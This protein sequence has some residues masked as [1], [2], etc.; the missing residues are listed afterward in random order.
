MDRRNDWLG[1]EQGYWKTG[2]RAEEKLAHSV[3]Q[4]REA[5]GFSGELDWDTEIVPYLTLEELIGAVLHG[6]A[7]LRECLEEI[8]ETEE[9]RP[10]VDAKRERGDRRSGRRPLGAPC[11][12]LRVV[13]IREL[14]PGGQPGAPA[15]EAGQEAGVERGGHPSGEVRL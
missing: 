6:E 4:L 8:A 11:G 15:A 9:W 1:Y 10:Q 5:P 7:R 12:P 13:G 3:A 2:P 14:L